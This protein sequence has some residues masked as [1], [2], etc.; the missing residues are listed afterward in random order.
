MGANLINTT[1]EKLAPEV[2]RISGG[3]V[4]F[5]TARPHDCCKGMISQCI[6]CD[7][8]LNSQINFE[9]SSNWSDGRSLCHS[10]L[11]TLQCLIRPCPCSLISR[12]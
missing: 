4:C 9:I 11:Q 2:E 1:A 6:L 12:S 7:M 10:M 3:K 5:L 8:P